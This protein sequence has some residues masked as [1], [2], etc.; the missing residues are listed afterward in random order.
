MGE[1]ESTVGNRYAGVRDIVLIAGFLVLLAAALVVVLVQAWPPGP[2]VSADGRYAFTPDTVTVRLFGWSPRLSRE[3]CLFIVVMAAGAL[4]AVV[5]ALRSLYWYVGNRTLRRSWLM[6]YGFLPLVGALLGL[7]V[8]LVLR[9]GLTS[10]TG[11]SS[12][13]NPY[14]V[15][16]IAALVG[17]FSRETAEKLSAVFATLLAHPRAGRDQALP[18][19]VHSVEPASGRVGSLV[20]IRGIGLGS[21]STVR[22]GQADAPVTDVSDTRLQTTVPPGAVTGRLTVTTPSGSATSATEFT[23]D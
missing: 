11:G 22:F 12:D 14:G 10:P 4:G 6:M 23:V 8:Y 19:Q 9:G 17:L 13:V 18:P 15:T 5:H 21:A 2:R 7:M 1:N 16:A 3:A 20:V